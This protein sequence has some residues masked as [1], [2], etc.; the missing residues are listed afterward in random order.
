MSA[1]TGHDNPYVEYPPRQAVLEEV[2]SISSILNI[3]ETD[4]ISEGIQSLYP[5]TTEEYF[6]LILPGAGLKP[7]NCVGWVPVGF[8]PKCGNLHITRGNCKRA[9]CP[10]CHVSW[11]YGRAES[12]FMR[13]WSNRLS[14]NKRIRHFTL[15]P[16]PETVASIKSAQDVVDLFP[17]AYNYAKSMG[18]SGGVIILHPYRLRKDKKKQLRR[19]AKEKDKWV[20]GEFSLWKTLVKLPNWREYVIFYPHFHILATCKRGQWFKPGDGAN[21]I[22]WK[23][24]GELVQPSDLF[25]CAMYLLSHT[26]VFT[27][28]IVHAI[29]WFGDLSTCNWSL[30]SA[31]YWIQVKTKEEFKQLLHDWGEEEE[32]GFNNCTE[33]GDRW[34]PLSHAPN[35]FDDPNFSVEVQTMLR[36]AWGMIYSGKPPPPRDLTRDE[37]LEYLKGSSPYSRK[38]VVLSDHAK[39]TLDDRREYDSW[40]IT[41]ATRRL[42]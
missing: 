14:E 20:A 33:C 16:S 42:A 39:K 15:S 11:R 19:I 36:N 2:S 18:V 23:G 13:I 31:F 29:R 34:K 21:G 28:K 32:V 24:I 12:V 8:C 9:I 27:H 1:P 7:V 17:W 3:T 40:R 38:T 41:L 25:R 4:R 35:Y 30:E 6:G 22:I 10:D 26:G 5:A 37:F